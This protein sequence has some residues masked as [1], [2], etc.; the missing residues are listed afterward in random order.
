[1]TAQNTNESTNLVKFTLDPSNPPRMDDATRARMAAMVDDD[2]DFSDIP[3]SEPNAIWVRVP[4]LS[5]VKQNKK[6]ITIRLDSE[7]IDFFRDT[8]SGYQKRINS[9]LKDYKKAV[10]QLNSIPANH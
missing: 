8:G 2:I 9:I 5:P 6:T 1:M 4:A 3:D 7:V 10:S